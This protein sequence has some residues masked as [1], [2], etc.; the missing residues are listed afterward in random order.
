MSYDRA[1][2]PLGFWLAS[3]VAAAAFASASYQRYAE[4]NDR[5]R[6][7]APGRLV[8][9]GGRR[10]HLWCFGEHHDGPT[11]IG[12]PALGGTAV[13]WATM[14]RALGTDTSVC[15]Y[16]R[17]GL[18]WS[19]PAGSRPWPR[20]AADMVEDLHRGLQV[21][22]IRPPYVLAGNSIGGYVARLFVARYPDE[23]A[24][25]VLIDSSHPDQGQRLRLPGDRSHVV[26]ELLWAFRWLLTW[27]GVRRAR[28]ALGLDHLSRDLAREVPPEFLDAAVAETLSS[29][30]RPTAAREMLGIQATRAQVRAEAG[31]LGDLPLTVLSADDG[32]GWSPE[33]EVVWEELQTELAALSND[34]VHLVAEGAGHFIQRD[35]PELVARV[36]RETCS[37]AM[38]W[39]S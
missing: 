16:D 31:H 35:D 17:A 32:T 13:E 20:T 18:G 22:G 6:F 34:S 39:I 11:V 30:Q 25:L 37:R 38:R 2:R 14:A 21:A 4:R 15:L 8:D 12:I 28:V 19:D 23:V 29:N 10:L 33:H 9:I 26:E 24:G 3:A 27:R 5:I 36:I 1:G 7:P